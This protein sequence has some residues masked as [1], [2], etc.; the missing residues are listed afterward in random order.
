MYSDAGV[1][2][3][4]AGGSVQQWN[5][6]SG[7]GNN[8][9]QATASNRP[10]YN[11]SPDRCT[12]N[13]INSQYLLSPYAG[14]PAGF[15]C[16]LQQSMTNGYAEWAGGKTSNLTYTRDAYYLGTSTNDTGEDLTS[17]GCFKR[18]TTSDATTSGTALVGGPIWV[19]RIT[20]SY[21]I[22]H[23]R[24]DGTRMTCGINGASLGSV[25]VTGTPIAIASAAIGCGFYNHTPTDFMS[26]DIRELVFYSSSPTDS[27]MQQL[28]SYMANK[29]SITLYT[30]TPLPLTYYGITF[31]GEA[32]S[33][34]IMGI[35]QSSDCVTFQNVLCFYDPGAGKFCRSADI[36]SYNGSYFVCH[37][38][39]GK[40]A[41]GGFSSTTTFSIAKSSNLL[42]WTKVLDVDCSAASSTNIWAPG[43]CNDTGRSGNVYAFFSNSNSIWVVQ[44]TDLSG[45]ST[46]TTPSAVTITGAGSTNIIDPAYSFRG[47]THYLW[48][49]FTGNAIG[50]ASAS[51]AAG[52]YTQVKSPTADWAGW[53][54]SLATTLGVSAAN[55]SIEGPTPILLADGTTW[56]MQ[57]DVYN[58]STS[59]RY[60]WYYS[61][62]T[63]GWATWSTTA[64]CPTVDGFVGRHGG[65]MLAPAAN[66][67][68]ETGSG[69]AV[70]GGSSTIDVIY[71]PTTSGGAVSSGS[72]S[73]GLV[74]TTSTS[75][76][77]VA[78]GTSIFGSVFIFLGAGGAVA[79]GMGLPGWTQ[80]A[81]GGAV[82]V[83]NVI[84]TANYVALA[85]DGAV[86]SGSGH[87]ELGYLPS[88]GAK[89]S[90]SANAN[91]N[92]NPT[93]SGGSVGGGTSNNVFSVMG[94]GGAVASGNGIITAGYTPLATGGA[95]ASGSGHLELGYLPS[96]GGNVSGL[97]SINIIYNPIASGGAIGSGAL[98]NNIHNETGSGGVIASG[99]GSITFQELAMG[100][101]IAAGRSAVVLIESRMGWKC[102]AQKR[103]IPAVQVVPRGGTSHQGALLAGITICDQGLTNLLPTQ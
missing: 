84:I 52:P 40:I 90:G 91:A 99:I 12:F 65:L 50:Y 79:G 69:G 87:L 33:H 38:N 30:A 44:A 24:F 101:M 19:P 7:S 6:Q 83:G 11:T 76:G 26:G 67:Y 8:V 32:P 96:G 102:Y 103:Y 58:T 92:Y 74:I 70:G 14:E 42:T 3:A 53:K 2:P 9:S 23:G 5:D 66:V 61:D 80:I 62:S 73:F 45:L 56:R 47:G 59:A 28:I 36:M 17:P 4:V 95:V 15:I 86:A 34:E 100:G 22:V 25:D 89:V 39:G 29:Y 48:Y 85:T 18:I 31:F 71:S 81:L 57:M 94:S 43:W 1:T 41:G 68:S 75:G 88:G 27:Q 46:W 54:A 98:S 82:S 97:T 55:L 51:A 63:D 78:G 77:V 35:L 13:A 20:G 64:V 49:A 10:K 21:Y 60:G 93:A 37:A 16:V 72:A